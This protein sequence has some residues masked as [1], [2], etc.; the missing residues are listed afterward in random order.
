MDA[1]FTSPKRCTICGQTVGN[2]LPNVCTG[3][4]V[5]TAK[6]QYVFGS[7]FDYTTLSVNLN[8]ADGSF[9]TIKGSKCEV[10]GF[11]SATLGKR[12]VTI[13]YKEYSTKLDVE[14]IKGDINILNIN[15]FDEYG[16]FPTENQYDVNDVFY[17]R[18]YFLD[19]ID[20]EG[21]Y[22][23]MTIR[24]DGN[25]SRFTGTVATYDGTWY[26]TLVMYADDA[27]IF[28]KDVFGEEPAF[29]F[30]LDVS[31]CNFLRIVVRDA[32]IMFYDTWLK[33]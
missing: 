13:N 22:G 1:T 21:D 32:D 18:V 16:A 14:I 15:L 6:T 31:G 24:L 5:A 4:T 7:F 10:V 20:G 2:K 12:T 9:E 11:S 17:D 33:A 30:D 27:L 8:Y 23:E 29:Q 3:I 26:E 25:F 28:S 19:G